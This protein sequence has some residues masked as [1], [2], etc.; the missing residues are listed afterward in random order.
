MIHLDHVTKTFEG[1]AQHAVNN[2]DLTIETG[3][4]VAMIGPSGC[5]KT[6]TMRMINQLETPT[7]GRIL[8]DGRDISKIDQKE[9]RRGIGYVIQQVG[10]FPHMTIARNVATVPRLLGWDRKRTD[11]RVDELLDLVGLEPAIMRQR[12]PHELSGGQRQRVGFA[13][14]LAA[15]PKIMLMDEPF[16]AIDPITRVRLQDEFR[17]ILRKVRKTVV[18]VTHDLDE[19]IKMGDR[20]AI[21][22]DGRLLQYDTPQEILARPA[23]DFIESFLGPDRA[24]KRL[25]LIPVTAI[26]TAPEPSQGNTSVPPD[27]SIHQA[28]AMML[29]NDIPGLQ[30]KG[31]DGVVIGYVG[32][33]T[34]LNADRSS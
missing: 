3:T 23:N 22:R 28:L 18:L 14:A 9:L 15:D 26:M 32:R 6:T 11:Q 2:L 8:V 17:E 13:R 4:T 33:N 24:I 21:M 10:L 20:I 29:S 16:G 30:I 34:I 31:A 27:T 19:A 12:L 7:R 25:N 5:G 1:S